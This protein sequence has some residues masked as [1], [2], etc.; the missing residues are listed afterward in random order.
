MRNRG[1]EE[2][3]AYFFRV[4]EET[5]VPLRGAK[6]DTGAK[7]DEVYFLSVVRKDIV[8]NY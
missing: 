7:K 1:T 3:K 8:V 6:K 4:A 2:G 5:K